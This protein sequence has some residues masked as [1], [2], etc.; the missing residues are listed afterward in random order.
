MFFKNLNKNFEINYRM[1]A[2]VDKIDEN[3]Q[4]LSYK[5]DNNIIK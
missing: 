1:Y 5:F 2:I 3:N 4:V